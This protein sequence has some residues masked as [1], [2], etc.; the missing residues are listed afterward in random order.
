MMSLK[1]TI[2]QLDEILLEQEGGTTSAAV[3]GF[4]GRGGQDIDQIFMGPFHPEWNDL[5]K[6]LEGQLQFHQ[7]KTKFSDAVTPLAQEL[8]DEVDYDY[9]FDDPG[10]NIDTKDF[11]NDSDKNWKFINSKIKYDK[12]PTKKSFVKKSNNNWEFIDTK[13]KY[14]INKPYIQEEDFINDS[15]TNWK[16]IKEKV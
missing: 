16:Y 5:E 12:N 3:G 14:D 1:D 13:L 2:E 15:A 10:Y 11:I 8:F 4:T 6:T 9:K 7:L